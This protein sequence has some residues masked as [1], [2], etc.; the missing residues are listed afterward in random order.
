MDTSTLE[1]DR[2]LEEQIRFI[3]EID[4]LKRV[5]RQTLLTD[6]SR[7]E[8][9]AEHSWHLA[10]MA[11]LLRE[12]VSDD[13]DLVKVLKMVLVHD[14]VEI[15][16][17]DTFCYDEAA[18]KDRE[19]RE[20][21]AAARIFGLLP[22]DQG[23]EL[24]LVWEEFECRRTAEAKFAAALDRMQPLLSNL[25][26]GGHSWRRHG[27]GHSQVLRRT[28]SIGDASRRLW[29]YMRGRLAEAVDEGLL[30]P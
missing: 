19:D 3:V 21:R 30:D 5:T 28:A 17:G 7:N 16:A 12:Y 8:N 2:R 9:S 23:E 14:L 13:L 10:V 22:A 20:R 29:N 11:L 18:N 1:T 26:T 15:D 24:R 25:E 27:V 4:R 6:R